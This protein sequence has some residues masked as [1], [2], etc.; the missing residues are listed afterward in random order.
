M[1][2]ITN[3][4]GFFSNFFKVLN[5]E[6]INKN[7]DIVVPYFIRRNAV[8][9]HNGNIIDRTIYPNEPNIWEQMFIPF[10]D[11]DLMKLNDTS[12]TFVTDYPKLGNEDF[13]YPLNKF[14]N[15]YIFCNTSIY[16]NPLLSEIRNLYHNC[17]SK[18]K[19]TQSLKEHIEKYE[20]IIANP[21]KTIA[22]FVRYPRHYWYK[23]RCND[24]TKTEAFAD[25]NTYIGDIFQEL[26]ATLRN[27]YEY[28][29]LVTNMMTVYNKFLKKYG[30]KLIFMKDKNMVPS[31]DYDWAS[32]SPSNTNINNIYSI[33]NLHWEYIQSFTDVYLASKCGYILSGSSNML[34]GA[35]T[36]NPDVKFKILDVFKEADGV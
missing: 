14:K 4:A 5:W 36:I 8:C 19:W 26:D 16:Y 3:V 30:D 12:N 28:I 22:V 20:K 17:Y 18:F 32:F 21:K 24:P 34:L 15:G 1:I 31:E 9:T 13:P 27:D 23:K 11:Y 7:N 25:A 29:Y 35:L 6:L 33:P 10:R 2:V